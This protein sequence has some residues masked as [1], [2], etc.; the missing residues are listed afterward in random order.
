M[1]PES[2]DK[3]PHQRHKKRKGA[4]TGGMRLPP[5]NASGRRKPG[6]RARVF[7][8]AVGI[9]A[10]LPHLV[11]GLVASRTG[12]QHTSDISDHVCVWS[13]VVTDTGN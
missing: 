9:S 10:A 4:E 12:R 13:F 6:G 5:R 2:N 3:C 1:G 8:G 11:F 7:P